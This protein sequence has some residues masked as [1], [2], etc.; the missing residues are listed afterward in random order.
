MMARLTSR[1]FT[2]TEADAFVAASS[3]PHT[4][5]WKASAYRLAGGVATLLLD[6]LPIIAGRL[7]LDSS[8]PIRRRLSLEVGGGEDLV[9]EDATDPLVPF[10]QAVYLWVRIDLPAGWSP[11]LKMGEY[12][13][14]SYVFERPSLVAVVDAADYSA[15]V[16][17][18]LHLSKRGYGNRTV[19][20]AIVDMVEQA[21]PNRVFNVVAAEAAS[22]KKI[23]NYTAEAGQGRWDAATELAGIKGFEAFFDANANLVIRPDVTDDND[24]VNP[25]VG[26]DI[27]TATNPVAVIRDGEGGNL[28]AMTATVTREGACNGV[29]VNL[30]ETAD[31]KSKHAGDKRRNV[32]VTAYQSVGPTAWGDTFGRVPIVMERN[33]KTITDQVVADQNQRAKR[34][35]HRRRGLVRYIDLDA[36]GLYWLEPDDK[37]RIMWADRVEAHYAQRVEFDLTGHSPVRVR[38]R[39]LAVTDPSGN[40]P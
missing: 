26:P 17:E 4:V 34:L 29:V 14:T 10:G 6:D 27:G 19:K 33:V 23:T 13:I 20:A 8:D 30:H 36:A 24:D 22:T 37:V 39:Q 38:T 7:V 32:Q 9:P 31:K 40:A 1:G 5:Q 16:N 28:V 25:G 21:L 3:Q 11:W 2:Q 18:F 35:L 12:P 15:A